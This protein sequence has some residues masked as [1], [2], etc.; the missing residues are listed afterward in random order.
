MGRDSSESGPRNASDLS[1]ADAADCQLLD[2]QTVQDILETGAFYLPDQSTG[3]SRHE[4]DKADSSRTDVR[5]Y[6][7]D[8]TGTVKDRETRAMLE[9]ITEGT[10]A[11]SPYQP[12]AA[13]VSWAQRVLSWFRK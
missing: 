7:A 9:E 1:I 13:P 2:D 6:D 4:K 3:D 10:T 8:A 12:E 11:L 5:D